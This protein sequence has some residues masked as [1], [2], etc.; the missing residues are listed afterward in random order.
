M[1]VAIAERAHIRGLQTEVTRRVAR[2][3]SPLNPACLAS[4][5]FTVGSATRSRFVSIGGDGVDLS[6]NL[7]PPSEVVGA[8]DSSLARLNA[9]TVI[10][11]A[12]S[13]EHHL[14]LL[15]RRVAAAFDFRFVSFGEVTSLGMVRLIVVPHPSGRS[16]YLNDR[17]ARASI[18]SRLR[19]FVEEI[20]GGERG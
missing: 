1:I 16:R 15:G 14:V 4:R 19:G 3:W 9:R 2:E 8:W 7:L 13:D 11:W 6:I 20:R 12:E 5:A 18:R 17:E 10:A